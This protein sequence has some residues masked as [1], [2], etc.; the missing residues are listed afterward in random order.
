MVLAKLPDDSE[1]PGKEPLANPALTGSMS[2]KWDWGGT[3]NT[4]AHTAPQGNGGRGYGTLVRPLHQDQLIWVV[5]RLVVKQEL[6]DGTLL[7]LQGG[8]GRSG[9]YQK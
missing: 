7:H 5:P 6:L 4:T 9:K 2:T 8:A 3:V 1:G